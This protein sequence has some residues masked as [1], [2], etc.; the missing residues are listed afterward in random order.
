MRSQTKIAAPGTGIF[1]ICLG[2][3]FRACTKNLKLLLREPAG[4][5]V[6]QDLPAIFVPDFAVAT[7]CG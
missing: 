7:C 3:P 4:V 2:Y 5:T 6:V 1:K